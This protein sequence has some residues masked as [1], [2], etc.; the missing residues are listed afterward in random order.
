MAKMKVYELAQEMGLQSKDILTALKNKGIEVKSHMSVLEDGQVED[1]KNSLKAPAKSEETPKA[2]E[3]DKKEQP[4]DAKAPVKKKKS[5]I[6]VSNPH[7]SKMPGAQIPRKPAHQEKKAAPAPAQAAKAAEPVKA[8]AKPVETS[9]AAEAP[10]KAAEPVNTTVKAETKPEIVKPVETAPAVEEPKAAPAPQPKAET[11]AE[12]PKATEAPK[13]APAQENRA[14]QT[15]APRQQSGSQDRN[16]DRNQDRRQGY[17]NGPRQYDNQRRSDNNNYQRRDGGQQRSFDGNRRDGGQRNN[18]GNRRPFDPNRQ[19]ARPG[20]GFG[21]NR[22]GFNKDDDRRDNNRGGFGGKQG[23]RPGQK[24]NNFVPDSPIKDAEKHRD[25]EKRRISQE[26]DKKNRK[27]LMYEED[28]DMQNIKGKNKP[29]KFIKPE[30][31]P[32]EQVEEQIKVITLPETL[33]IKELADKMKIQP[34]AIVKKLFMQGQIVTVN[35]EI[36][37]ETA[38]NIAIDYDIICEKEVKVDVIEE[39]LKEDEEKEEDMVKRP[40]V[41][42]VMGHVDHGKTSLLDAIRKTNVTDKEAGG[43]TQHIGA[44]TVNVNGEKITFLDTPGHEAF[45][46]MRMRGANSTDIAILVVA[47]D[48]GVMPQTVEAINHAKAAGIEII[49]AVNKIDKPGANVERVKQ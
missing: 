25:E 22:G 1:L 23:G 3:A 45:T 13:A 26:K 24:S 20:Q 41:I 49:V 47:A 10:V 31:K 8:A 21:G 38:E 17:N 11:A 33:T 6:F 44:Y 19:N 46:A 36:S 9:K 43:I 14:A 35:Q 48:D 5:I 2:A 28:G 40:P 7:N 16:S 29:G 34:S 12:A 32:V 15:S 27:D 37:Y 18:D 30:K 4:A 42:C 39:L